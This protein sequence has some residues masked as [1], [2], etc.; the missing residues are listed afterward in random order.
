M[1]E[2]DSLKRLAL[3]FNHAGRH[4]E[5]AVM[6]F[7]YEAADLLWLRQGLLGVFMSALSTFHP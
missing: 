5:Q 3:S 2:S 4:A 7:D 6:D 1:A